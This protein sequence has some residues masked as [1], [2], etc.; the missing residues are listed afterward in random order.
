MSILRL[1]DVEHAYGT[2]ACIRGVHLTVESGEIVCLVGPSGCGKTTLLRLA[3][4]LE[5]LDRGTIELAEKMVAGPQLHHPPE[6]RDVGLVFQDYALFPHLD[7]AANVAFGLSRIAAI[8]RADRV[9]EVLE[10]VD[11]S[12]FGN[13]FPH[14]LSGGEQQRVALARALAPRPKVLL[15]DEPFS[16]L[17][18]AAR[19]R[20]REETRRILRSSGTATLLVTHDGEEAMQLGDRIAL[21]RAGQVVQDGTAEELYFHPADAFVASFFG[22]VNRIRAV[23]VDNQVATPFGSLPAGGLTNGTHAEVIFRHEGLELTQANTS[24]T[25][26]RVEETRILGG[27][28]LTTVTI[29]CPDN[30]SSTLQVRH[31]VV[32]GVEP[33]S[34]IFLSLR[35]ELAHVFPAD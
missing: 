20:V 16:G 13:R 33:G 19:H 32:H 7:V 18:A 28:R 5:R 12:S 30:G 26:A 8:A 21:M 10:L 6:A 9:A 31:D 11:L 27:Q 29:E 15:L 4:G 34:Q 2:S 23:A 14:S 25:S 3:A 17:D 35:S 22:E 1:R 24:A